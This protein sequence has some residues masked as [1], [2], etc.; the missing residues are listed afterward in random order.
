MG[1]PIPYVGFAF[2]T[3]REPVC[4]LR[5][6]TPKEILSGSVFSFD[7]FRIFF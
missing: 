3:R 4:L 1:K 5:R 2:C 6:P 7:I